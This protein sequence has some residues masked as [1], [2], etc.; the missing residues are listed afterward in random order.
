MQQQSGELGS[1]AEVPD[2][3][4]DG[5]REQILLQRDDAQTGTV[6]EFLWDGARELVVAE[7]ELL[8]VVELG[9]D[10]TERSC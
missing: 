7:G 9:N 8:E 1:P 6:A 5:P 3:R 4:G 10:G 2:G